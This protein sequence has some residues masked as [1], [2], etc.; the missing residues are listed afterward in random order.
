MAMMMQASNGHNP[1]NDAQGDRENLALMQELTGGGGN[2]GGGE[3]D[4]YIAYLGSLAGGA[5][6]DLLENLHKCKF[7]N[8]ED[9]IYVSRLIEIGMY[10]LHSESAMREL[11][12]DYVATRIDERKTEMR[13]GDGYNYDQLEQELADLEKQLVRLKIADANAIRLGCKYSAKPLFEFMAQPED[14]RRG[15]SYTALLPPELQKALIEIN[16]RVDIGAA[17]FVHKESL[18]AQQLP[19][20]AMGKATL[21]DYALARAGKRGG[22]RR[23]PAYQDDGDRD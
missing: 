8:E 16:L 14:Q 23:S 9:K 5:E 6:A 19:G 15:R 17:W 22:L 13:L 10:Q 2:L 3:F 1:G 20:S 21:S 7:D 12:I 4:Q 11:H 18:A